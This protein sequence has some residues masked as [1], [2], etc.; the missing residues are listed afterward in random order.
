[1]NILHI[2]GRELI[3]GNGI[4]SAL[5][6]LITYQNRIDGI[7]ASLLFTT[8]NINQKNYEFD[9]FFLNKINDIK[10]FLLNDFR[11]DIVVFHE[12]Y[13]LEFI[14]LYKILVR[15]G[16]PYIIKPHCSLI[17]AAQNKSKIKKRIANFALF[18]NFIDN[19]LAISYLNEEEQENSIYSNKRY[20]IVNNGIE[21]NGY[22]NVSKNVERVRIIFLSRIDYYHKGIDFLMNGIRMITLKEF[23]DLCFEIMIYGTGK[24]RDVEKLNNDLKGLGN[25]HVKFMGPVFGDLKKQTFMDAHI[26]ILTS[27]LEGMPMVILE[28]LSYGLPCIVTKGTNMYNVIRNNNVGWVTD[29]EAE[30]IAKTIKQAVNEYRVNAQH[31]INSAIS[32]VKEK[33]SWEDIAKHSIIKYREVLNMNDN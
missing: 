9:I 14:N 21:Y 30:D 6:P 33:Y 29:Y 15:L 16:I 28:A 11:P 32:L 25:K 31:Y 5:V 20:I 23:S 13:Y 17:K 8:K 27:R 2:S 7:N 26:M 3:E 18:N 4:I 24:E 19:A 22:K 1:V 10:S 12:L